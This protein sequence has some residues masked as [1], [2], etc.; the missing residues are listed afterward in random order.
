MALYV[1]DGVHV[2]LL[3]LLQ[4]RNNSGC[5]PTAIVYA[6]IFTVAIETLHF[7]ILHTVN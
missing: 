1:F 2:E 3:G 5:D 7:D 4:H 6:W